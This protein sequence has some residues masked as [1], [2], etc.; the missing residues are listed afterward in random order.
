MNNMWQIP[1]VSS[2]TQEEWL[3][4]MTF[5]L[6]AVAS[7]SFSPEHLASSHSHH[8]AWRVEAG[9]A[10]GREGGGVQIMVCGRHEVDQ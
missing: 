10:G 3:D 4:C 7:T 5:W 9:K 1:G 6:R 2:V 8:L